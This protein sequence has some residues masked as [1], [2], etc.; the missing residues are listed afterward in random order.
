MR[1]GFVSPSLCSRHR[2]CEL[3]SCVSYYIRHERRTKALFARAFVH[4]ID[5]KRIPNLNDDDDGFI[6]ESLQENAI[7]HTPFHPIDTQRRT[8]TRFRGS[9]PSLIQS[10]YAMLTS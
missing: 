10:R 2:F 5:G 9:Q 7:A 8:G 4:A 3:V 1:G 6:I